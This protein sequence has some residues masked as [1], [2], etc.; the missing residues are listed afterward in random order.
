MLV[1]CPRCMLYY[2]VWFCIFMMMI[3][4]FVRLAGYIMTDLVSTQPAP[5]LC[6]VLSPKTPPSPLLLW[7]AY[8]NMCLCVCYLQPTG[9]Q[10]TLWKKITHFCS[11]G[12]KHSSKQPHLWTC[13]ELHHFLLP[14]IFFLIIGMIVFPIALVVDDPFAM[15][16]SKCFF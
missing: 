11:F 6:L 12:R 16:H 5:P 8:R 4:A 3:S 14:I 13:K 2:R 10:H 1:I 9:L 15:F 7:G